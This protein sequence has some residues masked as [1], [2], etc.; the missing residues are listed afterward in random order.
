MQDQQGVDSQIV[1][2]GK[3]KIK[4]I[5]EIP[6]LK[7]KASEVEEGRARVEAAQRDNPASVAARAELGLHFFVAGLIF[8]LVAVPAL[9]DNRP[10]AAQEGQRERAMADRGRRGSAVPA[11]VPGGALAED[12][13]PAGRAQRRADPGQVQKRPGAGPGPHPGRGQPPTGGAAGS[14]IPVSLV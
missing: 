11:R 9:E 1:Q 3:V 14:P 5:N 7:A 8:S 4:R 10:A 13:Q 12:G 6:F 2:S